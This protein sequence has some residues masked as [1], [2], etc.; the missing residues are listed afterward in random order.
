MEE[1]YHKYGPIIRTGPEEV[2]IVDPSIPGILDGPGNDTTKAVW[3]DFLLPEVA[4]NTTRNK[5]Y[6]DIRRR[7]WDRGFS[8][9]ALALYDER[10]VEYGEILAARLAELRGR[11]AVVTDWFYWFSFDVMGDFAFAKSFGMLRDEQWHSVVRM[12]RKAMSLLGPFSPVPWLAQIAF[13]FIPWMYLIRDWFAML[14]WCKQRMDDRVRVSCPI[15][16]DIYSYT[17]PAT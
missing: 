7:I 11:P 16:P 17:P 10:I 1:L 6:H 14:R 8:S 13:H 12:L 9:K 2:T 5:K 3:Y 4:V 15:P